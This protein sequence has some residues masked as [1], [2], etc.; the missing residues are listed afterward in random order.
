MGKR[1]WLAFLSCLL[2]LPLCAEMLPGIT[3][4]PLSSAVVAGALLGAAYLLLRPVLR[5]LT[6]PIGCAT[7]GLSGFAIDMALILLVARYVPG[8]SVAG[9]PWAALTAL[10][11]N[12]L[13][14]ITGGFS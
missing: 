3:A 14:L 4:H 10:L 13:T 5:L 9:L 6:L 12:G 11:V 7:L 2:A 1:K 8:F